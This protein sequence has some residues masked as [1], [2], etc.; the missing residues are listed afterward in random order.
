MKL[1]REPHWVRKT[2]LLSE[3]GR[4]PAAFGARDVSRVIEFASCQSDSFGES[5]ARACMF[6]LGFEVPELQ[7]ALHE[8]DL[9]TRGDP[10][11]VVWKEKL[12]EDRLRALGFTLV[13]ITW[14]D[15]MSPPLLARKLLDAGVRRIR[16]AGCAARG[17]ARTRPVTRTGRCA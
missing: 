8:S 11:E 3:L 10:G 13:R 6:D 14:S 7:V 12:R 9:Y 5:P 1:Q 17:C 4:L 2:A 15:L 16:Q